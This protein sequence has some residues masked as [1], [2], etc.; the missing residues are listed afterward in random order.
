MQKIPASKRITL[1]E[2]EDYIVDLE[3]NKEFFILH[4]PFVKKFTKTVYQ[5]MK[6]KTEEL[7]T[8]AIDMGYEGVFLAVEETDTTINKFVDR[9]G[10]V[11]LGKDN[12]TGWNVY[13]HNRYKE[14]T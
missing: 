8:M 6:D 2:T 5:D 7:T 11:L 3:Y 14:L 9:L 1:V 13:Q 4:L 10:F 12:S